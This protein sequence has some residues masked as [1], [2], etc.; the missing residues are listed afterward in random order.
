MTNSDNNITSRWTEKKPDAKK[1]T[2]QYFVPRS[3]VNYNCVW[4]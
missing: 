4:L 1:N 3:L 2:Q